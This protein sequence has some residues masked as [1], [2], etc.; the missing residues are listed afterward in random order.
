MIMKNIQMTIEL[1]WRCQFVKRM[2]LLEYGTIVFATI[3]ILVVSPTSLVYAQNSVENVNFSKSIEAKVQK[4]DDSMS[5]QITA[6]LA[7]LSLTGATFLVNILKNAN[8]DSE[9]INIDLAKKSFIKAFYLF[10]MCAITIFAFD[11][12]QTLFEQHIIGEAFLDILITYSLFG[13]GTFYLVS[14][15]KALYV[16]YGAHKKH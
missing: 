1:I 4:L 16:T 13:F 8:Q 12:I 2:D 5:P 14:A 9:I 15:A 11:F 10:L 7:A 6:T 3:M